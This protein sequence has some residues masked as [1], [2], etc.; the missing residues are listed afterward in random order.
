MAAIAAV[1]R[2]P[3][4]GHHRGRRRGQDHALHRPG[5]HARPHDVQGSADS[6]PDQFFLGILGRE[7]HR[8]GDEEGEVAAGERL[9][10]A[11]FVVQVG[12]EDLQGPQ[13]LQALEVGV[14]LL[15]TSYSKP[16]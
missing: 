3:A 12:A 1:V 9:V 15:V 11:A 13:S 16:S 4:A 14:L 6:R 10:E 8:S 7:V 5:F 2:R